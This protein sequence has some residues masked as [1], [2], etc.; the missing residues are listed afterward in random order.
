MKPNRTADLC[1]ENILLALADHLEAETFRGPGKPRTSKPLKGED[2]INGPAN[3]APE[4]VV[5]APELPLSLLL[6]SPSVK[7]VG[8]SATH[9]DSNRPAQT[10]TKSSHKALEMIFD[11]QWDSPSNIWAL[12]CTVGIKTQALRFAA[13]L[14]CIIPWIFETV[15]G[16]PLFEAQAD[17]AF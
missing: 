4:Y 12:G 10:Q 2:P 6:E 13:L 17:F 11:K 9:T 14:I 8:F 7:I 15:V 1:C 5:D 3:E 16:E